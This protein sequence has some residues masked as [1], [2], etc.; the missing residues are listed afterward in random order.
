MGSP[1]RVVVMDDTLPQGEEKVR[2]VREMFDTIAPRYDLVNRIMTFGL[3]VRWRKQA[4]QSLGLP[5][6][7]RVLDLA[8]GTGD[9]CRELARGGLRPVG[10]DLSF[11]MLV[12]ARTDAPLVQGDALRLSVPDRSVDGVTCGFA[13]RNL[14][15]L[16]PFFDELARVVRPG[17]RI[18]LLDVAQPVNPILRWG[19]AIYFGHVVPRIGG[20]LSDRAAYRYLPKSAAYLPPGDGMTTMLRASGFADADRRLLSGGIT[21]LLTGTRS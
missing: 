12:A 3:D 19:H 20:L 7:S 11:G 15:A 9:F 2:A 1:D 14:R 4:T 10:I 21:Q 17:G 5:A 13:L 8:A 18:A 6:G 16:E